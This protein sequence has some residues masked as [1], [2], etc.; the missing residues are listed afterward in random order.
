[1]PFTVEQFLDTIAA[2]NRLVWPVQL[3]LNAIA[4]VAVALIWKRRHTSVAAILAALWI[5]MG[6]AY[7]YRV[8]SAINPAAYFLAAA[9][10]A[11]AT[12]FMWFGL[13]RRAVRFDAPSRS[14]PQIVGTGLIAYALIVYPTTAW[15]AGHAYPHMPTFG[16]P[17]PTLIFTFGVLALASAPAWQ[18]FV[19]PTLWAVIG[20][21]A[22][23]DL[24]MVEDLALLPAALFAIA[25]HVQARLQLRL[26][27][28]TP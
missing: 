3:I 6:I 23:L 7:H 18:L 25:V 14:A 13:V 9:F 1:M 11:Q 4:V 22:A 28:S 24:G 20:I 17:C 27:G 2:Y 12:L 26:R 15:L 19:I 5:W 10:V 8:F 16:L 21:S